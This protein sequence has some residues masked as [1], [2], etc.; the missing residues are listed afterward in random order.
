MTSSAPR[1]TVV[2]ASLQLGGAERVAAFLCQCFAEAGWAT[3]R[4]A[5]WRWCWAEWGWIQRSW[6]LDV[7]EQRDPSVG[8]IEVCFVCDVMVGV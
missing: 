4:A 5:G 1:L 6:V 2:G 7:R 3:L 8:L